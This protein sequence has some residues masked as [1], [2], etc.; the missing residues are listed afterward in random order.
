MKP[1]LLLLKDTCFCA[2]AFIHLTTSWCLH[3]N[4]SPAFVGTIFVMQLLECT[5]KAYD[6]YKELQTD[7]KTHIPA[8]MILRA[9]RSR[10]LYLVHFRSAATTRY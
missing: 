2:V 6:L 3:V 7:Y 9:A 10:H 5:K 1:L 4:T 8:W